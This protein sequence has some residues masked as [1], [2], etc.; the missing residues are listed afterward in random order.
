MRFRFWE[1]TNKKENPGIFIWLDDQEAG[2]HVGM[3]GFPK[4][5]LLAYREAISDDKLGAELEG[6]IERI[7][8]A[9]EYE[10]GEPHY[11]RVPRGYAPDHPRAELLRYNTFYASSPKMKKSILAKA[12]FVDECLDHIEKMLPLH[13]WLLKVQGLVAE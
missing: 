1:G 12:E 11:K 4:A 9:G 2:L 8:G 5:F 3:H 6:V 13:H 10:F 7:K